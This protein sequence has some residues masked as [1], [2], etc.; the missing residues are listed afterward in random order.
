MPSHTFEQLLERTA[1]L[2]GVGPGFWD[3]WGKYHETPLAAR[4]SILRAKGF[5]AADAK[6]LERSLAEYTRRE[7]DTL[8]PV[9]LVVDEG[10]ALEVPVHAR[11][12]WMGESARFQVREEDGR[13]SR[14]ELKLAGLPASGTAEL[15]GGT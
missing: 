6:S 12:E 9:S 1:E 15:T 11:S 13:V 7:W 10:D 5:D 4:Q 14:F 8:L 3:I 2:C